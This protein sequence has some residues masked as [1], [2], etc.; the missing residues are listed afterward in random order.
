M[1]DFAAILRRHRLAAGLTQEG[2]GE[3]AGLSARGVQNLERGERRPYA[4]TTTHL[5][6]ALALEGSA[7]KEFLEAARPR[8]APP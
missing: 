6:A 5:I 1:E 4:E 7:R 2:L 8:P 3:R